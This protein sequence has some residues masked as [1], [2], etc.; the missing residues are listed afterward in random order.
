MDFYIGSGRYSTHLCTVVAHGG[1]LHV[2]ELISTAA[3]E[4]ISTAAPVA[5]L[6]LLC[7]W[8][9][10]YII[11]GEVRFRTAPSGPLHLLLGDL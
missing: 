9:D 11:P 8:G 5:F 6:Q 1:Y 2:P 10:F 3:V 7:S 4:R